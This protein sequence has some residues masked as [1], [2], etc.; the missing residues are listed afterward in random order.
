MKKQLLTFLTLSFALFG[1]SQITLVKEINPAGDG[2]PRNLY[3]FDG[4]IYFDATDGTNGFELWVSDGTEAG[5]FLVKDINPSGTSAPGNW[6]EYNN[7]LYF[8]ANSGGGSVLH[9]TDGTEAGTLATG[10]TGLFGPVLVGTEIYAVNSTDTNNLWKFTGDGTAAAVAPAAINALGFNLIELNGKLLIVGTV[11][12]TTVGR[13]LYEYD[14]ATNSFTLIKDI[15]NATT[16]SGAQ[17][18]VSTGS[19]VYFRTG[20]NAIW[21]TDGTPA[22]TQ[23]VTTVTNAGIGGILELYAWDGK[24]FFE[25]DTSASND[26]L[27]VYDPAA[28]TVTNVSNIT[29][30]TGTGA[31]NHDPSDFAPFGDFLYYAGEIADDTRQWLFRTD[32]VNSV[33][34]NDDIFDIDDI[35]VLN[36]VL[37]FEG[38]DGVAGNELYK[39]DPTTL[40]NGEAVLEIVN[41]YPNPAKDHV[42]FSQNMIGKSYTIFDA[43]GKQLSEGILNTDRLELNLASGLYLIRVKSDNSIL[44]KKIIIE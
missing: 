27:W 38:D 5:T 20:T 32:G 2:N 7:T 33:R 30:G 25:G 28:D 24:I 43:A 18:F 1:F 35:A 22:G 39:A 34:V 6:F 11:P 19:K 44:T 41:V 21:E 8:S 4:K 40:S 13:E 42:M 12:S 9:K 17:N 3:A 31:N 15:D 29:G 26:Q 36:G 23:E 14:P 10:D 16:N 37:Y